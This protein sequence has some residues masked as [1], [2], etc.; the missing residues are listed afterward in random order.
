VGLLG[1]DF[2]L[3]EENDMYRIKKIYRGAVWDAVHSPLTEPGVEVEEGDYLLEVNGLALD[4]SQDPWASFQDLAGEVVSL[5]IN[6]EPNLAE[7]KE[8]LVKPM[9][10]EA[11]LRNLSWIEENRRKVEEAT[12]GRVGYVY[13]PDTGRNGQNELVRQFTPQSKKEGMI[14]DER[15]NG[16]GQIPDRFIELMNRPLYNYWAIRHYRDWQTPGVSHVGPKVM[17]IN[18][19]AGSGGDAFPYYFRK[20]GLGPLIG[21]RTWGGLVGISHNPQLIDGGWITAPKFA[22][23][24][25][26]GQWD[27]EGYGIS[28]DFEVK[29]IPAKIEEG[30]DEQLDKAIEVVLD[31]LEENPPV[32]PEKPAYPD[33]RLMID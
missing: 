13:V 19:W 16:G 15:F 26:E 10:S 32:K 18:S 25:T 20:A 14:I 3:D 28:P 30:K 22:F 24:N 8:I 2:E 7:A 11:R 33:R 6:S 31:L 27:V 5:T 1:C 17:L 23:F 12:D 9:S 21:T 4:T 29:N